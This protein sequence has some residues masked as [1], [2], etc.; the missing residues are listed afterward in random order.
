M[1]QINYNKKQKYIAEEEGPIRKKRINWDRLVYL[2]I[3][4]FILGSL[5]V[6]LVKKFYFISAPGMMVKE[7]YVVLLPYDVRVQELYVNEDDSVVAGQ[8]LLSFER[9]FRIDDNTLINSTRSV[10]EWITKERFTANRSIQVKRVE[11]EENEKKIELIKKQIAQ[12][13]KLVILDVS[14]ANKVE[15]YEMQI[16]DLQSANRVLSEEIKYWLSYLTELP[17]YMERYQ[18]SLVEQINAN[19][20]LT[21]FKSPT[22]GNISII[23]FKQYDLVYKGDIIMNIEMEDAYVRA[24]IPQ[25]EFGSIFAGDVV[26]VIFPDK[27]RGKGVIEKIYSDLEQLP[28]E[29]QD[30]SRASVRSLL[31][32]VRPLDETQHKKWKLN[33]RLGVEIRKRRFF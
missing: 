1:R 21:V 9:D 12:I 20:A 32:I 22:N 16:N 5:G 13:E 17:K 7:S 2:A 26:N 28:P 30:D 4:F 18:S 23:N 19:S 6:Y 15:E 8:N 14:N 25:D 33:N 3:L 11:I 31:A 10:D 29:Y 24:Y 27:T